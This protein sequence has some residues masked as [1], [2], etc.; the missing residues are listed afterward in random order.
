VVL[1]RERRALLIVRA[2]AARI[3]TWGLKKSFR[4]KKIPS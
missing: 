2:F 4:S 1:P 3:R